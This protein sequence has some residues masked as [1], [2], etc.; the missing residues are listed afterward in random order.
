MLLII[1]KGQSA[2]NIGHLM[3]SGAMAMW[4]RPFTHGPNF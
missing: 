4:T 2:L 3:E 1:G